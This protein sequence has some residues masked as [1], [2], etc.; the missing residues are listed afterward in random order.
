MCEGILMLDNEMIEESLEKFVLCVEN[1]YRLLKGVAV[2]PIL[3]RIL[4]MI[5]LAIS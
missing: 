4:G 5:R 1:Y 2:E 3:F